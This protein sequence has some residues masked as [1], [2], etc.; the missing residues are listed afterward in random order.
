[1]YPQFLLFFGLFASSFIAAYKMD[2]MTYKYA[3]TAVCLCVAYQ[4]IYMV[5]QQLEKQLTEASQQISTLLAKEQISPQASPPLYF[6][7]S[8][9]E[10]EEE[11][12]EDGQYE[13]GEQEAHQQIEKAKKE[14]M[15]RITMLKVF[16]LDVFHFSPLLLLLFF[17][18]IFCLYECMIVL[19]LVLVGLTWFYLLCRPKTNVFRTIV[20]T[21]V[22][23]CAVLVVYY[24]YLKAIIDARQRIMEDLS[25]NEARLNMLNNV[26]NSYENDYA[27]FTSF[28][29]TNRKRD[30]IEPDFIR[31]LIQMKQDAKENIRLSNYMLRVVYPTLNK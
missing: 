30:E 17:A 1:M 4:L 8:R 15:R 11:E 26:T 20:Y 23:I 6:K 2:N 31:R 24:M 12:E 13:N 9:N 28:Y 10:Q 29:E 25:E 21:L 27:F 3:C 14:T 18:S 5:R 22:I 7:K 16:L 19:L